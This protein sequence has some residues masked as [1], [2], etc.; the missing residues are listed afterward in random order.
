MNKTTKYALVCGAGIALLA[1]ARLACGGTL[2]LVETP[3]YDPNTVPFP[4]DKG[5]VQGTLLGTVTHRSGLDRGIVGNY[6]DPDGDPVALRLIV[7]P[8]GMTL[9]QDPITQSYTLQW[10]PSTPGVYPVVIAAQDTPPEGETPLQSLSTILWN[11]TP[12]NRQP[13][14]APVGNLYFTK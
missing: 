5:V 10:K 4:Y 1:L 8:T 12:G 3:P 2:V 6:Y 13:F 14:L 9:T 11:V 7:A